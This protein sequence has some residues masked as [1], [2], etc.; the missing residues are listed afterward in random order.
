MRKNLDSKIRLK[1]FEPSNDITIPY[2]LT[3]DSL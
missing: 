3:L 2:G 1:I